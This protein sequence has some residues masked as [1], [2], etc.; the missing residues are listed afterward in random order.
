[1][2]RL[3]LYRAVSSRSDGDWISLAAADTR[4]PSVSLPDPVLSLADRVP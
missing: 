1:M 2:I 3:I 4:R